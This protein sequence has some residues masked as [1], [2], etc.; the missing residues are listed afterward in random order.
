MS[1]TEKEC[2]MEVIVDDEHLSL[3]PGSLCMHERA[4]IVIRSL[5]VPTL[6]EQG[7]AIST[8][9][10]ARPRSSSSVC[11]DLESAGGGL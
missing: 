8:Q 1:A 7:S 2:Q 4:T 10:R 3:V 6:A 11:E 5:V 9:A